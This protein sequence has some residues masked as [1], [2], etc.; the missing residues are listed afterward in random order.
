MDEVVKHREGQV[1]ADGAGIGIGWVR[2]AD[3]S[4]AN[5]DGALALEDEHK[6]GPRGDELDELPEE[7]LLAVD[8]VVPLGEL[9]VDADE[10]GRAHLEPALLEASED[11]ARQLPPHGIRLD[12]DHGALD[13][14]RTAEFTDAVGQF[15]FDPA[16]YLGNIRADIPAFDE[17]Q[18]QVVRAAEGL[19]VRD[20]LDL[21]TGTGETA[22]RILA[23]Y[24]GARLTGI[25]ESAE[26]LA[27]A[28]VVVGADPLLLVARLQDPLPPGPYDLV[29][30]A[31]AVHHLDAAGKAGLFRRVAPVLRPGGRFVLADVVVPDDSADAVTPLSPGFDLPDPIP[32]QL[33]WLEEAGFAARLAWRVKDLAVL[34]GDLPSAPDAAPLPTSP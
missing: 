12:Q 28:R 1:A 34:V 33:A 21:G 7:R 23:L 25:D 5:S 9:A 8:V 26:M 6:S 32:D 29:I 14:H 3:R 24:P 15:H 11:L 16:T 27:A 17:L 20:V 4:A 2:R 30:S 19:E 31:L 13:S 18:D 22:R 10:L